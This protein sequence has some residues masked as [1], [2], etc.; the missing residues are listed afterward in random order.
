MFSL[1]MRMNPQLRCRFQANIRERIT[2]TALRG[3]FATANEFEQ[4]KLKAAEAT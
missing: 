3:S 2:T 4:G 1:V